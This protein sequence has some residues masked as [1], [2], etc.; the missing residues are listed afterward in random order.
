MTIAELYDYITAI[1][2]VLI[3]LTYVIIFYYKYYVSAKR[4][5]S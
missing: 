3:I 2:F 1:I 5:G 4:S